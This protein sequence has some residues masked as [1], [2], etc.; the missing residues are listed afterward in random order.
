MD[1]LQVQVIC[2]QFVLYTHTTLRWYGYK[3]T[4]RVDE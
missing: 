3:Q 2:L 4:S 1:Y